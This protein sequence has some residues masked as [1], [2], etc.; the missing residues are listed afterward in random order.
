MDLDTFLKNKGRGIVKGE[1]EDIEKTVD[2]YSKKSEDELFSELK[3]AKE[4][5][6]IN[7]NSVNEFMQRFGS[8]LTKEQRKNA[9]N[10]L[11]NLK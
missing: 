8:F 1:R 5:G 6:A 9:E 3:S 4:S 10:L 11:K 7:E 2:D